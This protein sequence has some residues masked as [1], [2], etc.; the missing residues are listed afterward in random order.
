MYRVK[1]VPFMDNSL[2]QVHQN[3]CSHLPYLQVGDLLVLSVYLLYYYVSK[4][5]SNLI[6]DSVV[7]CQVMPLSDVD[8]HQRRMVRKIYAIRVEFDQTG[9]LG[10]L[11]YIYTY[12][13]IPSI[14]TPGHFH[15]SLLAHLCT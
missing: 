5:S 13:G 10:S 12:S 4:P 15:L 14:R 6:S 2:K 1:K 9:S 8:G 11:F 7:C 3:D